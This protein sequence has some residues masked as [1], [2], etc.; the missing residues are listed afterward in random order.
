MSPLKVFGMIWFPITIKPHHELQPEQREN[1]RHQ[2]V[3]PEDDLEATDN[4]R[5]LTA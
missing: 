3:I 5:D 4:S 2:E 1:S